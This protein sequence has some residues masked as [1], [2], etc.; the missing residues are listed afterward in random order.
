MGTGNETACSPMSAD[1]N[2]GVDSFGSVVPATGACVINQPPR[3]VSDGTVA[4]SPTRS[5]FDT[6]GLLEYEKNRL[7]G[8]VGALDGDYE[9]PVVQGY[10]GKEVAFAVTAQDD[11]DCSELLVES[12]ILPDGAYLEDPEYLVSYDSFPNGQKV[13]KKLRWPAQGDAS[14]DTT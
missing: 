9:L 14:S 11:D 7:L 8:N 2:C 6:P 3:F 4:L 1:G 13:R 10:Y 12:T 5:I